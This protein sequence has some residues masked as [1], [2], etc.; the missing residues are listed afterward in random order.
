MSFNLFGPST[1]CDIRVGY[2]DPDLG[3]VKEVSI[4][5]ANRYAFKNPG[6]TFIFETRDNIRYL[7]I[8]EVNNLTPND[9][10]PKDNDAEG[11]CNGISSL[12]PLDSPIRLS[13]G[14]IVPAETRG[15][16]GSKQCRAYIKISGGGGTGAVANPVFGSDGSL[17]AVDVVRGG[18]GYQY[19]PV[20][21]LIDE[22]KRGSGAVLRSVLGER[23]PTT[24]YFDQEDDFEFY[25]FSRC[26]EELEGYGTRFGVNGEVIGGW[27]PTLYATLAKD[28]IKVEI[29]E[30]QDYLAQGISP[31]WSTRKE[32]PL[33]VTFR[34][35]VNRIVHPVSDLN[36]KEKLRKEGKPVPSGCGPWMN[37]YAVSPVPPQWNSDVPGSDY[38]GGVATMVWEENSHTLESISSRKHGR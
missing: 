25:D 6:T 9:L 16:R 10:L 4:Y 31:F 12:S 2:I 34:D 8:N 15:S 33:S 32:K 5:D 26:T 13:D 14:T 20:V 23:P 3:Y 19:P 37:T 1:K 24:E 18:F 21:K 7:N 11:T 28:P 17:L 22:C 29:K 35:R 30:Y 38:A 36:Y 27:D